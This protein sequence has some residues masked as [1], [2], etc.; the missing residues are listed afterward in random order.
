MSYD[1]PHIIWTG[2]T[3][4]PAQVSKPQSSLY[5]H[6]YTIPTPTDSFYFSWFL[7]D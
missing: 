7:N 3:L 1:S 4:T 6:I 5:I 2:E